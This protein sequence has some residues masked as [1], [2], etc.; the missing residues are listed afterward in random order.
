MSTAAGGLKELHQFHIRME[1]AREELAQGPR[2]IQIRRRKLERLKNEI[3][4]E[5]DH[6]MQMRMAADQKSL[7]WKTHEAKILDLTG[8]LN[9]STTNKEFEIIKQQIDADTMANSVLEDEILEALEK[10]DKAEQ[11]VADITQK[12]ETAVE[13]ERKTK[14]EVE[15]RLPQQRDKVDELE[16][17]LKAG[18]SQL[19]GQVAAIYKRLVEAHGATAL[20]EFDG[21]ICTACNAILIPNMRVELNV[22]KFVFCRSCGRLLYKKTD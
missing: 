13:D 1:T 6:I 8:K 15:S 4:E 21:T 2:Q 10:I 5:R 12:K 11:K 9:T 16:A 3:E 17:A 7:Q 19:P 18:E 14:A 20:A 22:G